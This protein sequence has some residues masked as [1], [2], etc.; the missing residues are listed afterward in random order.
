MMVRVFIGL[1]ANV[2]PCE[3]NIK[4]ALALLDKEEELQIVR[5]SSL[6]TTKPVGGV[7]QDDFLNGA[8]EVL[9]ELSAQELLCLLKKIEQVVGR[10]Q[11]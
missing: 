1:G 6:R 2:A 7:D 3:A 11:R 9:T 5:V 10:K 4:K 8:V